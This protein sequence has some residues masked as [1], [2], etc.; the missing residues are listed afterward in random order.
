M[1]RPSPYIRR[2]VSEGKLCLDR[3]V[4]VGFDQEVTFATL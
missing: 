3:L 1:I 2:D 4:L